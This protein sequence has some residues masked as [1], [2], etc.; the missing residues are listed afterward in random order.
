MTKFK[1]YNTIIFIFLTCTIS[2]TSKKKQL[3]EPEV[4]DEIAMSD[5]TISSDDIFVGEKKDEIRKINK[6]Q[7]P[8]FIDMTGTIEDKKLDLKQYFP[9]M[10]VVKLQHPKEENGYTFK[11]PLAFYMARIIPNSPWPTVNTT[12][13]TNKY[14]LVGNLSGLFCYNS[15]G[16]YQFTLTE[17]DEFKNQKMSS[18]V[19]I[20]GDIA[21]NLLAGFS[22]V[23]DVCLYTTLKDGK[24]TIHLY[25]LAKKQEIHNKELPAH[26]LRLLDANHKTWI[27]YVYEVKDKEPRPFMYSIAANG[28]TLCSFMNKNELTDMK[29]MSM[30]H[31]PGSATQFYAGDK[32]YMRQQ[33]NDTIF[34]IQSEYELNPAYIFNTGKYRATIQDIIKGNTK[35]KYALYKVLDTDKLLVFSLIGSDGFYWYDKV[36][37]KLYKSPTFWDINF[38]IDF[39]D[40]HDNALYLSLCK[41]RIKEILEKNTTSN[42]TID[43]LKKLETEVSDSDIITIIF[44]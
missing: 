41:P 34:R 11:F 27:D 19:I 16:E 22:V 4:K 30:F 36:Q 35:D 15:D 21:K 44:E 37:N 6:Q 29:G 7:P 8:T 38:D 10:R 24:S 43:E 28:D 3:L 23:G 20:D 42:S 32:L 5:N 40:S 17:T 39:L 14:L 2:C 13:L 18:Q 25:D 9:N 1:V 12:F 31:N 26:N 33:G